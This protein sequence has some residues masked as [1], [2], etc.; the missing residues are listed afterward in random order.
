M[1][2]LVVHWLAGISL[3]AASA[4]TLAQQACDTTVYPLSAPTDRFQ[5]ADAG[6]V[7]DK[8]THLMWMR[9]SVGQTWAGQTCQGD[10]LR[11]DWQQAQA[12]A[13]QLNRTGS[14][15]F[16]DWRLP[17]L[18][19]L[20]TLT[21]R[22]CANPRANL[23]VFPSTPA[24]FYW[25]STERAPTPGQPSTDRLAYALSFGADGAQYVAKTEPLRVRLVRTAEP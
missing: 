8:V 19:E 16:N 18:T 25:S 24:D 11:D 7:I 5:P 1:V 3:G 22:Q 17:K 12:A 2:K 4:V 6:A 13:E 15:F 21:E 20:A 23:V 9:C 14:L 10:A